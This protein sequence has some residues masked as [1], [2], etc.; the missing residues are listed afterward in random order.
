MAPIFLEV[1]LAIERIYHPNFTLDEEQRRDILK[2]T[3]SSRDQSVFISI[4]PEL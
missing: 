4:A 1:I 2:N 3:F